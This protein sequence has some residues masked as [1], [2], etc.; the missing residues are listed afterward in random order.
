MKNRY[1]IISLIMEKKQKIQEREYAFPYHHI[2]KS[3]NDSFSQCVNVRWGYAYLSYLSVVLDS[4]KNIEFDNLLDV[5]CGDGKFLLEAN[6]IF[7]SKKLEG[8]DYSEKAIGFA[9][10]FSPDIKF[11][12]GD[13]TKE[14]FLTEKYD[15]ITLIETLEHIPTEEI[16]VFLKSI[17]KFLKENGVF[18]ITVPSDN[19]PVNSKHYQHFNKK[20][21]EAVISHHF[22]IEQTRFLNKKSFTNKIIQK[23]LSNKIFILNQTEISNLIY[24]YYKK[25]LLRAKEKNAERIMVICKP[26]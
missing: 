11:H 24:K 2:P 23:I 10:A 7:D 13:I 15:I 16:P 25:H 1:K 8:V 19:V 5:G 17:K 26:V 20:S 4:I 6:K 9:K 18:I 22:K 12:I 14:N 21:L 3:K